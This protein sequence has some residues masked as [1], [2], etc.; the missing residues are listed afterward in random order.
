METMET[1]AAFFG[2]MTL[3]NRGLLLFSTVMMLGMKE[4]ASRLHGKLFN[5]EESELKGIYFRFLA[6]CSF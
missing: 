1:L 5:M 4:F 3:I 6:P 2:W